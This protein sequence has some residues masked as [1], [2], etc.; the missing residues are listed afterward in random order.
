M[1]DIERF[2][3]T[4]SSS[5][6][7]PTRLRAPSCRLQATVNVEH[8]WSCKKIAELNF[9]LPHPGPLS[10]FLR[11]RATIAVITRPF[12]VSGH[13]MQLDRRDIFDHRRP[14]NSFLP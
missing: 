10:T 9:M 11:Y 8:S 4:A 2:S 1:M 3:L 5:R 6:N 14:I 7:R 12:L 13:E